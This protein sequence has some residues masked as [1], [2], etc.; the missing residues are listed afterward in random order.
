MSDSLELYRTILEIIMT[1]HVHFHDI[2]VNGNEGGE[3][4]HEKR[5]SIFDQ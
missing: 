4:N 5:A 2:P 1:S 3:C